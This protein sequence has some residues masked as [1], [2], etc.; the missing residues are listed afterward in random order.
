LPAE[1]HFQ[2]PSYWIVLESL[3]GQGSWSANA[4]ASDDPAMQR[5]TDGLF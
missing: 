3:D 4:A 1:F 2:A 5:G